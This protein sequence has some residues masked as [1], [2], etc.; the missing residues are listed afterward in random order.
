MW[1]PPVCLLIAICFV[2]CSSGKAMVSGQDAASNTGGARGTGGGLGDA[3]G[4]GGGG[5]GGD[6][7]T[8]SVDAW[9]AASADGT[10]GGG[11]ASGS[12]EP[13]PGCSSDGWC[14]LRPRPT[15]NIIYNLH[16]SAGDDVWAGG[17]AGTALHWDG[18]AW[19]SHAVDGELNDLT[20]VFAIGPD[21]V[22]ATSDD[23]FFHWNGVSWTLD[24]GG[25]PDRRLRGRDRRDPSSRA[26]RVRLSPT[27]NRGRR[28]P[29]CRSRPD[30]ELAPANRGR[31]SW[32][33]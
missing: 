8:G 27:R 32:R 18:H 25:R 7:P 20:S 10:G 2:G 3:G 28:P 16:G 11:G 5:G 17:S 9:D 30:G 29:R 14:W 4:L 26:L 13:I 21:D 31:D 24:L 33:R 6:G 23:G 15:G 12:V 22:W 19:T 1:T